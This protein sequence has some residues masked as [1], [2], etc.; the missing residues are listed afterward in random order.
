M[1]IRWHS[2]KLST[3]H[4]QQLSCGTGGQTTKHLLQLH[5]LPERSERKSGQT[6]P[7]C[8]NSMAVWR[9]FRALLPSTQ[10]KDFL[11]LKKKK[12]KKTKQKK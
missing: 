8:R 11:L 3:N 9:T 10:T 4:K 1:F 6:K 12:K 2:D 7:Q 5:P